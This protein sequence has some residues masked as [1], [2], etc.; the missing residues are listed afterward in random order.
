M[1]LPSSDK[2]LSAIS[3]SALWHKVVNLSIS[4]LIIARKYLPSFWMIL[5]GRVFS[6]SVILRQDRSIWI[7]GLSDISILWCTCAVNEQNN[8]LTSDRWARQWNWAGDQ[9]CH[10]IVP[11]ARKI[12]CQLV[13]VLVN[14]VPRVTPSS[15]KNLVLAVHL[16]RGSICISK[17]IMEW[18]W[19]VAI[20]KLNIAEIPCTA[21]P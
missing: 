10:N 15:L 19:H 13:R 20:T 21:P 5:S 11:R 17:H 2:E 4:H 1:F 14:L 12:N 16:T 6:L 9:R 8:Q 7:S 3:F 18:V